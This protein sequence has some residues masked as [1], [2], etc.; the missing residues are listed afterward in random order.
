VPF[1]ETSEFQIFKPEFATANP[2]PDA[3]QRTI[4]TLPQEFE[5]A[6]RMLRRTRAPEGSAA[7]TTEAINTMLDAC[8]AVSIPEGN[9]FRK[10]FVP[11]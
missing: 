3:V 1:Y 8:E 7:A 10:V 4:W 9:L 11:P 2:N 6:S 5:Q